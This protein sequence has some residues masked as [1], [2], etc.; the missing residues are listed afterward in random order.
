MRKAIIISLSLL[1]FLTACPREE[2]KTGNDEIAE[3]GN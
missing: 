2:E 3:T 1:V